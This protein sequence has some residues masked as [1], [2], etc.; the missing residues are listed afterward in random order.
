MRRAA[1][2]IG[3]GLLWAGV[4]LGQ[5]P[6]AASTAQSAPADQK[7]DDASA[8]A[9]EDDDEEDKGPSR[10][11]FEAALAQ[12]EDGNDKA[13]V[14]GFLRYLTGHDAG[15]EAYEQS[16]YY[17]ARSLARLGMYHA[18]V[19]YYYNVVKE[20]KRPELLPDALRA[21]AKI[22]RERPYDHELVIDDLMASTEFSTL[23]P[24]VTAFTS[25]Q[26]GRLDLLAQRPRWAKRHFRRLADAGSSLRR[27]EKGRAERFIVQAKFAQAVMDLK[28]T[29]A[30]ASKAQVE[31]REAAAKKIAEVIDD[32][33]A[34]LELKNKARRVL[35]EL[36]FEKGEFEE[37]LK[38]YNSIEVPFL[39]REEAELFLEKAWTR[40]YAGDYRGTLGILLTL[41]APSYRRHFLPERYVLKALAY[42]ELCHY[43]A[44]KA[45][46]REF[47]R[48]YGDSL[49]E[50]RRNREPLRD[51]VVRRAAVQ[52]RQPKRL[53]EFLKTLRRE[54]ELVEKLGRAGPGGA[55]AVYHLK[56]IYDLKIAEVDRRLDDVVKS[57]AERVANEL[58]EYEEQARLV[59]YE[60]SMEVFRRIKKGTGDKIV[61][62]PPDPRVPFGGQQVYYRFNGEYWN[63]E[64]HSYQYRIESRCFASRLF[65]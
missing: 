58:L 12:A 39:S 3:C 28:A 36:H 4:A 32:P 50:L 43:A 5:K 17:L 49:T 1:L 16:E 23:P 47:S 30:R 21:L 45:S 64:L 18:A 19:E 24:D 54:R 62:L 27:E 14:V 53:F 61:R 37:A 10:E 44:A 8:S 48:I 57:E 60:V 38:R 26:K 40:Y 42:Q 9:E 15:A 2:T 56:R 34:E 63:D 13:A 46:A 20:Q 55:G 25:Y 41:E 29:H 31:R 7:A 22:M 6:A 33:A 52:R 59:D 35:A 65:E 51:E 11:V